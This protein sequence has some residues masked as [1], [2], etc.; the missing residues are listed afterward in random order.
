MSTP[1]SPTPS[2]AAS[3]F[4]EY[5]TYHRSAMKDRR[6]V[7]LRVTIGIVGFDLL[8]IK[9]AFDSVEHV[10]NLSAMTAVVRII[11]ISAW[12]AMTGLLIQIELRNRLD[13]AK[14][15]WAEDRAI[16][17][18]TGATPPA[19]PVNDSFWRTIRASWAG[20]WPVLGGIGLT[21]A[22]WWLAGLIDV[23]VPPVTSPK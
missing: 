19:I 9:L 20:T 14:Y 16:A 12:V 4:L 17:L 3:E 22:L 23:S 11:T 7:G 13:R 21:V 5:A 1:P 10:S 8:A 15:R 2:S 18:R 6:D